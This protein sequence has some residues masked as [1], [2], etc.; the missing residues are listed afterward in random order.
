MP[1]HKT[2][3]NNT[4]ASNSGSMSMLYG[5]YPFSVHAAIRRFEPPEVIKFVYG[6]ICR[7]DDICEHP[8]MDDFRTPY[9]P[10]L[11]QFS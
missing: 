5:N 7:A 8:A 6:K 3:K 11:G 1:E 9:G 2:N 10:L 4:G